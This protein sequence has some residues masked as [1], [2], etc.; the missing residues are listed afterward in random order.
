MRTSRPL[1]FVSALAA[2]EL[3]LSGPTGRCQHA[4]E[5]EFNWTYGPVEVTDYGTLRLPEFLARRDRRQLAADVRE[6]MKG[7]PKLDVEAVSQLLGQRCSF[8]DDR[9]RFLVLITDQKLVR[10][11]L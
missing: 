6:L 9:D 1:V 11:A 3:L 8:E 4:P 7:M 10:S 2:M 5:R